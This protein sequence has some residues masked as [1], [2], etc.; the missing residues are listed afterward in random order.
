MALDDG[1]RYELIDGKLYMMSAP[2]RIHQKLLG[3]FFIPLANYL[4]GKRCEVYLAPFDVRLNADKE[5]DTVVQPDIVVVCDHS[6][7][8]DKGCAGSPDLAIEILSPHSIR[9]DKITKYNRYLRAGIRE[10]WIVDPVNKSVQVNI[11]TDTDYIKSDYQEADTV[12]VHVLKGCQIELRD[13]FD[14]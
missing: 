4:K 2:N 12:P 6:K 5:D 8:N 14:Y 11:L 13:I 9:H 7:L 3:N 10:Y 1:N